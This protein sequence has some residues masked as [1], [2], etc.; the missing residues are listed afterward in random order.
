M[1]IILF[2]LYAFTVGYS[3]AYL[4]VHYPIDILSGAILGA[5]LGWFVYWSSHKIFPTLFSLSLKDNNNS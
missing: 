4:G 3:R 1:G 5:F 2:G